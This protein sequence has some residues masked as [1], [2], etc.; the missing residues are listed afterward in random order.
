MRSSP[1]DDAPQATPDYAAMPQEVL[2]TLAELLALVAYWRTRAEAAEDKVK[3]PN[4]QK[5]VV[6][7]A[8]PV[9]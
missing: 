3:S 5:S 9:V 8:T 7:N 1:F 4:P 2:R 6:A